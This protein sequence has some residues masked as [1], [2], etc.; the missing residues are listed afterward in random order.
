MSLQGWFLRPRR[1]DSETPQIHDRSALAP[2]LQARTS[3]GL[4]LPAVEE[5]G[6]RQTYPSPRAPSF[7]PH[8]HAEANPAVPAHL[9]RERRSS[10][11]ITLPGPALTSAHA[12]RRER[13]TRRGDSQAGGERPGEGALSWVEG[14]AAPPKRHC[15][16]LGQLRAEGSTTDLRSNI[17]E[18]GAFLR[19]EWGKLSPLIGVS[20]LMDG[21]TD[22]RELALGTNQLRTP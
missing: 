16:P 19:R 1:P 11:V 7:A 12:I 18:G 9:D 6:A 20:F 4:P 14:S 22:Q 15:P 5:T 3:L 13:P 17:L 21:P 8:L 2:P 10:A